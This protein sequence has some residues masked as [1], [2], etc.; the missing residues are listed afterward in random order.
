V[1]YRGEEAIPIEKVLV[2]TQHVE[3]R[4]NDARALIRD[5]HLPSALGPMWREDVDVLVN[6]TGE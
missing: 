2:S 3:Q 1:S 5:S 4:L 6:P